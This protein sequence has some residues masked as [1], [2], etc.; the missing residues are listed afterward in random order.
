VI[1]TELGI[2]VEQLDAWRYFTDALIAVAKRPGAPD[3]SASDS[4]DKSEPFSLAQHLAD[5][6]LPA[7]SPARISR[8]RSTHCA[9][10]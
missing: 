5:K 1:E 3:A 7:A 9:A 2:R 10:R 8:K 4:A 6:P